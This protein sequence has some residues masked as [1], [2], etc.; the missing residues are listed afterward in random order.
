MVAGHACIIADLPTNGLDSASAYSLMRTM[1]FATKIGFSMMASVVQPSPQ[2]LRLFHR[3]MVMS[4]GTCI[5]FGP[6]SQ[7]EEFFRSAGFVRPAAK[8]LPQFIEEITLKPELFYKPKRYKELGS[9]SPR[10]ADE[11]QRQA[12]Q[13]AAADGNSGSGVDQK[14]Q[15]EQGVEMQPMPAQQPQPGPDGQMAIVIH[16]D[17]GRPV[18]PPVPNPA[19]AGEATKGGSV[20]HLPQ[21]DELTGKLGKEVKWGEQVLPSSINRSRYAAFML[22]L[23]HYKRSKFYEDVLAVLDQQEKKKQELEQLRHQHQRHLLAQQTPDGV[24]KDG[25]ATLATHQGRPQRQ[26][27]GRRSAAGG[28]RGAGGTAATTRLPGCSCT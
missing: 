13:Q 10:A 6:V 18:L 7:A 21:L 24:T 12:A 20:G 23:E 1:R 27:A 9:G 17:G 3:V 14:E 15:K 5:Y 22:V 2:L 11:Q 28:L 26:R 16:D 25:Q 19:F 8:A 4:K